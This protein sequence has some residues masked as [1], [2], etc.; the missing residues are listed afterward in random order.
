LCVFCSISITWITIY[1]QW[2]FSL[3]KLNL[4]SAS[5]I[6]F[7]YSFHGFVNINNFIIIYTYNLLLFILFIHTFILNIKCTIIKMKV[8]SISFLYQNQ[9]NHI[10]KVSHRNNK[11][12][13]KSDFPNIIITVIKNCDIITKLLLQK[14]AYVDAYIYC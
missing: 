8:Y 4:S 14:N 3:K 13:F 2:F 12:F 11:L 7:M 5:R 9:I 6:A 10:Y 1:D